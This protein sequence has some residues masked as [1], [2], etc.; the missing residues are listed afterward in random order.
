LPATLTETVRFY[1]CANALAFKFSIPRP[2]FH[3]GLSDSE[4]ASA[5]VARRQ[6]H[7][8]VYVPTRSRSDQRSPRPITCDSLRL[9][10]DLLAI[11]RRLLPFSPLLF[12]I[13][14]D[15]IGRKW[16]IV[17]AALCVAVLGLVF[18]QQISPVTL[19]VLGR[20]LTLANGMLSCSF[21]A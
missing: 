19:V 18:A 21:H 16:Q 10:A 11:A 3:G 9:E 6:A 1:E 15:R 7:Q 13:F 20:L 8:R 12:M 5:V 14:A 4:S 17:T 2:I